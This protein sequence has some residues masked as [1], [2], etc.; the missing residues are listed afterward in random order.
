[1]GLT[2]RLPF[3]V[4]VA[5]RAGFAAACLTGL[6]G[7]TACSTT[8]DDT[9]RN[10][11]NSVFRPYVPDVVQGN[12]ISSEQYA[13]LQLGM[14]R[15]QV[16]QILGTPLLADYFH[17]NR[18]D[19]I[20]EFK[21]QKEVVG[22]DRR[23]T[24]FFENDKVVKFDGDALPTEAELV[25]EIDNYA[26]SKRSFWDM[27]TGS[28]KN[29]P[30]TPLQQPEVLVPSPT[31]E[32]T[33][34]QKL[35]GQNKP[36]EVVTPAVPVVAPSASATETKPAERTWWQRLT[37]Q[38]KSAEE[39]KPET[40]AAQDPVTPVSAAPVVPAEVAPIQPAPPVAPAASVVAPAAEAKPAERTWWQ[41]L[42]GQNKPAE[43]VAPERAAVQDSV[44]VVPV[45]AAPIVPAEIA[46]A[47][48]APAVAPSPAVPASEAKP[49]ERTW[50][51]RLTGQNKPVE[52]AV[53]EKAAVQAPVAIT[54]E[55][56]APPVV[57]V[58]PATPVL[59][60]AESLP[61]EASKPL[62]RTFWQKLTGQNKPAEEAKPEA[63]VPSP[64][65][66]V[67]AP[68]PIAV[69]PPAPA[70]EAKPAERTWWQRLTGQN[71]PAPASTGEAQQIEL[72]VAS[73]M[74]TSP[75]APSR[76]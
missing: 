28:N 7:L 19:Y 6:L 59:A 5:L 39:A 29:P 12:F 14:S 9:Q 47:Q 24:I 4:K 1:M 22:K 64:A 15:E 76:P 42:T 74:N 13:K 45:S 36:P 27:V 21:R 58:A 16:K 37:G 11:M 71:K 3:S 26:K 35:T 44:P 75:T 31:V 61:V 60:P 34:W 73:P 25:A 50:W 48:P 67:V 57:P 41:R 33:W 62:E 70:A 49:T 53:P 52:V 40:A 65:T 32:R 17:A 43:V 51:Q 56:S 63:S 55:A 54:P 72:P 30:T 20:F 46:P 68:A 18:W 23:V 69:A 38:N 2:K 66:P 8:V 10:W